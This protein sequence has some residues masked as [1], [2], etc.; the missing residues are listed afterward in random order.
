MAIIS[1]QLPF[2]FRQDDPHLAEMRMIASDWV[3]D[4]IP[5]PRKRRHL[6]VL[7][8]MTHIPFLMSGMDLVKKDGWWSN[9][10]FIL[11]NKHPLTKIIKAVRSIKGNKTIA[12]VI[13]TDPV[14]VGNGNVTNP[15]AWGRSALLDVV[16]LMTGGYCAMS[17]D[18]LVRLY[19][20][21][22]EYYGLGQVQANFRWQAVPGWVLMHCGQCIR[23][24]VLKE[25]RPSLA[26]HPDTCGQLGL[27]WIPAVQEP[28][29]E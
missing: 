20:E 10:R 8:R 9:V 19:P 3:V 1:T 21:E 2:D 14:P 18:D 24:G 5:D 16:K 25:L 26:F 27:Q 28:L 23:E 7:L 13:T 12:I 15:T 17:L 11:P 29:E 4:N 22:P 6:Q